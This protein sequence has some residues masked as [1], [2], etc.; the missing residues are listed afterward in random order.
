[1]ANSTTNLDTIIQGQGSQDI[2]ANSLFDAASP[3]TLYGR[4]ASTT[5]GLTWG[6]YG[7]NILI[8]NVVTAISNGTVALTASATNY[9]EADP[10]D[11]TVTKNTTA[12]TSGRTPLYTVVTGTASITSYTDK[13][14]SIFTNGVTAT[15]TFRMDILTESGSTKTLALTDIGKWIR[16]TAAC[17]TTIP[18]NASVAITIGIYFLGIQAGT[19]QVTFTAAG[20]VTLNIP[21]GCNART[22]GQGAS[23]SLIKVATDTWDLTG[24]LEMV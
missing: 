14:C 22:R 3:A 9:V 12:F 23:W 2:K 7:G 10:S 15:D 6:Y 16:F 5:A 20:G 13:R 8:S 18:T 1:M 17:D 11:G 21:S 24:D 4:R 19:S